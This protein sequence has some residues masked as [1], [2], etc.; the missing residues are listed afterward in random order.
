ME[1]LCLNS[2]SLLFPRFASGHRAVSFRKSF[3]SDVARI[4]GGFPGCDGDGDGDCDANIAGVSIAS[5]WGTM[6]AN[7]PACT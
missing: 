6:H 1:P 3:S 4:T 7:G 5:S 2:L